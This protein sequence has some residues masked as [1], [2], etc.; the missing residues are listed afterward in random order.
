M[1]DKFMKIYKLQDAGMSFAN[2]TT[3]LSAIYEE[4]PKRLQMSMKDRFLQMG[5][6]KKV[7]DELIKTAIVVNYGQDTDVQS[8]VG[9]VSL[10]AD[11]NA[12]SVKNGNKGVR[13]C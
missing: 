11:S 1:L 8:F 5:Y 9:C 3:L 4:F 6:S 13:C 2:I 7:I 10:A 12:W